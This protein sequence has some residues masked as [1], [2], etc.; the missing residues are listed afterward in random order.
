MHCGSPY[1]KN[2]GNVMSYVW[3]RQQLD[4]YRSYYDNIRTHHSYSYVNY[5]IT[6]EFVRSV[7]PPCLDVCEK[8][9]VSVGFLSFMEWVNGVP[10]RMG[11]DRA[12]IIGVNAEYKGVEGSYYLTV[13]ETEEVNIVTGR[14]FWG[15]PKKQGTIDYFEDGDNFHGI[16]GRKNHDLIQ[17]NACLGEEQGGM[18]EMPEYYFDLRCGYEVNARS[19]RN[20]ELVIF[21]NSTLIKRFRPITRSQLQLTGSPFDTG[22]GTVPVGDFIEGGHLGGETSYIVEQVVDLSKDG[23]DYAPYLMGRL[24]DDWPDVRR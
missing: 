1:G 8:P 20:P 16:A 18:S 17:L 21:K 4:E 6:A 5:S 9:I 11:R 13:L 15:M 10:N 2:K 7:L 3:T 22:V 19:I 23:V 14:E 12:A 24:Y